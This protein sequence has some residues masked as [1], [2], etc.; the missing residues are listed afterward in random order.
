[1]TPF[2][3]DSSVVIKWFVP[4]SLS[5]EALR[6]RDGGTPMHAP[7]FLD[8][9][10]GNIVWKKLRRGVL[11]RVVADSILAKLPF[12]AIVQHFTRL[13]VPP[14]FDI[15]ARA[16][17]TVYDCLYLTLAVQLGGQMVTADDK[18]V[19]SLAGSP[20]AAHIIKLQDVP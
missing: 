18:L 5:A 11:T 7:D 2:I 19:N 8:A 14:A 13:L 20:W 9:E 15:A 10:V 4:E 17:R 16:G 1:M 6:V 12:L 3:V